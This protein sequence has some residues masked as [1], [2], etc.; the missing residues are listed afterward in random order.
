MP[1]QRHD[2]RPA[3]SPLEFIQG[4]GS[5]NAAPKPTAASRPADCF[6][7][8]NPVS[9]CRQGAG[10][11]RP[12]LVEAEPSGAST[13]AQVL[14]RAVAELRELDFAWARAVCHHAAADNA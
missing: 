4:A 14:S 2:A 9:G 11:C 6:A 7:E 13:I 3:I 5:S 8:T 12:L 10:T 1:W